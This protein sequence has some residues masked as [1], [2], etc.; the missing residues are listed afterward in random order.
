VKHARF[1]HPAR[2]GERG[3]EG[4]HR[5]GVD[6]AWIPELEFA[7]RGG[8]DSELSRAPLRINARRAEAE[9]EEEIGEERRPAPDH[10]ASRTEAHVSMLPERTE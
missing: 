9:G 3:I 7:F 1:R 4:V 2:R 8:R 5:S 6:A 10:E